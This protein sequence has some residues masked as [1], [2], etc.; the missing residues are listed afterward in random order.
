MPI[1][2]CKRIPICP[3]PEAWRKLAGQLDDYAFANGIVESVPVPLVFAGW[4]YADDDQ[5][6]RRWRRTIDWA[7]RHDA[8]AFVNQLAE[9]DFY[10]GPGLGSVDFVASH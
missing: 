3:T 7:A 6:A 9:R 4:A 10:F 2:H 1:D 8:M 5:R